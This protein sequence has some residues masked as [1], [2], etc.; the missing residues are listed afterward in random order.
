MLAVRFA[1][2][3]L[4]LEALSPVLIAFKFVM[5]SY[6]SWQF[7]M[8]NFYWSHFLGSEALKNSKA[9][10]NE[11]IVHHLIKPVIKKHS[12]ITL[13]WVYWLQ[14]GENR[15]NCNTVC[16]STIISLRVIFIKPPTG[17]VSG[18]VAFFFFR[19]FSLQQRNMSH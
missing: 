5:D 16:S 11:N 10:V 2:L 9:N 7:G 15:I 14:K 6:E 1:V 4:W 3:W 19:L 18:P 13:Y 8:V 12:A 17:S